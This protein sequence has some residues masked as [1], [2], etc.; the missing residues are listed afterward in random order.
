MNKIIECTR[1]LEKYNFDLSTLIKTVLIIQC[2]IF[3]FINTSYAEEDFTDMSRTI[4][5]EKKIVLVGNFFA[6]EEGL[7]VLENIKKNDPDLIFFLGDLGYDSPDSW[8]TFVDKLGKEKIS[9]V[10]GNHD[11]DDANE[12]LA[13][14]GLDREFYSIDYENIH[15]IILS[16]DLD[17]TKDSEQRKFL[18][19]DLKMA[20][21]NPDIK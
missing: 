15:F 17:Y 12:F 20:N 21:N 4:E 5:N 14:Y 16:S 19:N 11:K 18:E 1:N 2:C 7:Q 3:L 8:F 9:V 13:H 6:N 10:I